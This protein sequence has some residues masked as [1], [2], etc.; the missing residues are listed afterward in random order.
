M[1]FLYG[2]L[3]QL[4]GHMT[5]KIPRPNKRTSRKELSQSICANL[6]TFEAALM[7]QEA[8]RLFV[9]A[10]AETTL[11]LAATKYKRRRGSCL[12]KRER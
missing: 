12:L 5:W 4:G 2:S 1:E 10:K 11:S 3:G 9:R 7:L 8:G 6:E